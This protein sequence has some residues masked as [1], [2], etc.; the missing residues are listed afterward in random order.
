MKHTTSLSLVSRDWRRVGR[1]TGSHSLGMLG[2]LVDADGSSPCWLSDSLGLGWAPECISKLCPWGLLLLQ[3]PRS[4]GLLE[5]D[6]TPPGWGLGGCSWRCERVISGSALSLG[7]PRITLV[8]GALVSTLPAHS[9]GLALRTMPLPGLGP[10]PSACPVTCPC[11]LLPDGAPRL[12][13]CWLQG[14]GSAPGCQCGGR[15]RGSERTRTQP[16]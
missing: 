8:G 9:T 2:G 14:P 11:L 1:L 16:A 4:E 3:G 15:S 6:C 10:A 13:R 7:R 5:R 12:L